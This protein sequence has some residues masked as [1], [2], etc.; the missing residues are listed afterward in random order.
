MLFQGVFSFFNAVCELY[1]NPLIIKR[2]YRFRKDGISVIAVVD[3]RRMNNNGLYPVKIEVVYR[4]IQKY[5][6]TG[7]DVS[8]QEFRP[9][10]YLQQKG[11]LRLLPLPQRPFLPYGSEEA[12]IRNQPMQGG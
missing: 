5:F 11:S 9:L 4:R 1:V 3:R 10:R 8:L 12:E 2:M 6:L 7:Q